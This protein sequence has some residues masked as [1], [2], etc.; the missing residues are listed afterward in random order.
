LPYEGEFASYGPL[1][2]IAESQRVQAVLG[3]SRRAPTSPDSET[4][5]ELHP[6]AV[7]ASNWLPNLVLAVDGS[8]LEHQVENGFPG[9]EICYLTI[10]SVLLDVSMLRRLDAAR[11]IDP[12]EFRRTQDA[13]SLDCV[14]PGCNVVIDNDTSAVESLRRL[15][16]EECSRGRM[17]EEGESLLDT[18]E[19]LLAYKPMGHGQRCPV[20]DCPGERA[21][22]LGTGEYQCEC[23]L[24]RPLFS[25]DALRIHERMNPAGSNGAIFAEVMQVFERMW[26]IHI[27]RTMEQ[28]GWLS[29]LRGLAFVLDGPLA[30]FGQPAWLS[31]AIYR[32]LMRLNSVVREAT[33]G[34]DILF[35]GIEKSG[36]FHDHFEALD[37]IPSTGRPRFENGTLLLPTLHYIQRNIIFSDGDDYG[38]Q[39]YFGRKFLYKTRSGARIVGTLPYLAPGHRDLSTAEPSQ[40]PRLADALSLIDQLVSTRYQNALVPLVAAHAEASIPLNLGTQVLQ[41]LAE[42]LMRE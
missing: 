37:L 38:E 25:T 12:R 14:L 33:R 36:M 40:Y 29:S 18:Y 31:Q 4:L 17:A 34:L 39:T 23:Q 8:H 27:L 42:R 20:R 24:S 30:V 35:L 28:K 10:A 15:L 9:A 6:A 5:P 19:A 1:R 7:Q 22:T 26:I 11:P 13:A 32:E 2:R 3:R 16:F 21:F 41:Q